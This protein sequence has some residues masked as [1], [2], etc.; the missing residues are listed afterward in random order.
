[1]KKKEESAKKTKKRRETTTIDDD[2]YDDD[3]KDRVQKKEGEVKQ[4][5]TIRFH[6]IDLL[7]LC[8]S[9]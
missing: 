3:D 2:D 4:K 5:H 7:V 6:T 1:M 9:V 8:S